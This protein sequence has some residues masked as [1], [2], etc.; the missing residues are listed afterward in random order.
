VTC[1]SYSIT[2]LVWQPWGQP[3]S[4]QLGL[5]FGGAGGVADGMAGWGLLD[6]AEV[7]VK[8]PGLNLVSLALLCV[9]TVWM[10]ACLNIIK[11]FNNDKPCQ[12]CRG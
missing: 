8:Q 1:R 4:K 2:I 9:I 10:K 11:G 3:H 12:S 6:G 5:R 7:A